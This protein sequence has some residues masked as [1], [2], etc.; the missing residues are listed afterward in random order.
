MGVSAIIIAKDEA[1]RIGPCLE[2]VNWADEVIVVIDSATTDD[3]E[4]LCRQAG[5]RVVLQPWQGFTRQWQTALDVAASDW[6]LMLAAD[7][8][9]SA[10]LRDQIQTVLRKD[11]QYTAYQVSICRIFWDRRI[12]SEY[13]NYHIRLFRRGTGRIAVRR[14]HEAWEPH[15]STAVIGTLSGDILHYSDRDL[16]HCIRKFCRYAELGAEEVAQKRPVRSLVPAV[17]HA[18]GA[19]L[20]YY[21]LKGG[22]RDGSAGLAYHLGIAFYEFYKY[23]LAYERSHQLSTHAVSSSAALP[24]ATEGS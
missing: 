6:V 24:S 17:A 8:R 2:S 21:V 19:F 14:V 12:R 22:F 4:A 10:N 1:D 9:V 16:T 18:L 3:T 13:P 5:A 20:K 7:E 15:D 23:A 11:P